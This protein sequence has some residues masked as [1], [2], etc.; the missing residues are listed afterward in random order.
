MKAFLYREYSSRPINE[1][2]WLGYNLLLTSRSRTLSGTLRRV[3]RSPFP[4]LFQAI[5][6]ARR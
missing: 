4:E 3:P 6:G 2:P 5:V 1:R